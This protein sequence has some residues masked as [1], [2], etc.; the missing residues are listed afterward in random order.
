MLTHMVRTLD[1]RADQNHEQPLSRRRARFSAQHLQ[2][3]ARTRR[4]FR[5]REKGITLCM[6]LPFKKAAETKGAKAEGES[7]IDTRRR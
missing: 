6:P 7:P 5:K 2:R 4:Q 3:M 1:R